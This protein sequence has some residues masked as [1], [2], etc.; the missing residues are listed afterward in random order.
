MSEKY[1]DRIM[2]N[3]HYYDVL[4]IKQ[5]M[6]ICKCIDT[7]YDNFER[8]FALGDFYNLNGLKKG[9]RNEYVWLTQIEKIHISDRNLIKRI[10]CFLKIKL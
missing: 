3:K 10:L 1:K 9:K 5:N 8:R 7:R 2:V 4:E 6:L